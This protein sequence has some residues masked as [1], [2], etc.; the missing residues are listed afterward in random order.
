MSNEIMLFSEQIAL[1]F[2]ELIC[3]FFKNTYNNT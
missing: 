1:I 3:F 2:K